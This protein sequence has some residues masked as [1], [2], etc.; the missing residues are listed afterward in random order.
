MYD[1]LGNDF[2]TI[3]ETLIM[4]IHSQKEEAE[5][6]RMELQEAHRKVVESNEAAASTLEATLSEERQ[7]AE[8][9]RANLLSQFKFLLD[10]SG[11]KQAT[12]LRGK[13]SNIKHNLETSHTTLRQADLKYGEDMAQWAKQEQKLV[14]EVEESKEDLMAKLNDHW[15]V[16]I[17]AAFYS[18]WILILY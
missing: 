2:K 18:S 9:E 11:E 12:R 4:H 10:E 15:T 14:E 1:S 3:F 7:A 5:K 13:V 8:M 16:S 6:L 17:T